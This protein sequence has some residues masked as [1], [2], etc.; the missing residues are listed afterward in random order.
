MFKNRDL[1]AKTLAE[2]LK[3]T[4]DDE[5]DV[6]SAIT[7]SSV[8]TANVVAEELGLPVNH[9]I[10][11]ELFVP[12]REDLFFGAVSDDGTIYLHDDII[13]EFK[14][15]RDFI[16][17][18]SKA[19]RDELKEKKRLRG[20]D[21]QENIRSKDVLLVADGISSGMRMASSLGSCIKNNASRKC[22]AAPFISKHGEERIEELAGETFSIKNPKFVGSVKD[23]YSMPEKRIY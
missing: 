11:T 21:K 23:G 6:V 9:V 16:A 3:E 13:D 17:D 8:E 2:E 15:D 14:I 22:V 18:Y 5:F 19:R 20:L 7:F 4:Y 10:S 1:A 12:G